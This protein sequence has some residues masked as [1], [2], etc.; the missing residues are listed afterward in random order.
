MS[1]HRD[2]ALPANVCRQGVRFRSRDEIQEEKVQ[3]AARS[4][5]PGE[6]RVRLGDPRLSQRVPAWNHF[7]SHVVA[8][9]EVNK[10]NETIYT[11]M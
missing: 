8:S 5:V 1:E 4:K 7:H 9:Q 10:K 2:A 11:L 3:D 6:G